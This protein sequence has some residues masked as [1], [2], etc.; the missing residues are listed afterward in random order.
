MPPHGLIPAGLFTARFQGADA[1]A[2]GCDLTELFYGSENAVLGPDAL[3]PHSTHRLLSWEVMCSIE[4]MDHFSVSVAN[5]DLTLLDHPALQPN[6]RW[7]VRFGLENELCD[8]FDC[9]LTRR[10]GWS[11]LTL[12]GEMEAERKL[13]LTQKQQKWTRKR[14]SDVAQDVFRQAGL[15]PVVDRT[16]H[17]LPVIVRGDETAWQFL[18]RKA[19]ETGLSYVVYAQGNKGYF[20]KQGTHKAP[21]YAVYTASGNVMD[22]TSESSSIACISFG[23]GSSFPQEALHVLEEPQLSDE[24]TNA[25][26]QETLKGFDPLAKKSFCVHANS[27]T[28]QQT[29][30]ASQPTLANRL[31]QGGE[32]LTNPIKT[33]LGGFGA[34]TMT[35]RA[36]PTSFTNK[37]RAQECAN[38][39]FATKQLHSTQLTCTVLGSPFLMP[40]EV[41]MWHCPAKSV[42]GR[43]LV[44]HV[45]HSCQSGGYTCE[46]QLQRNACESTQVTTLQA[47]T[48]GS[49][50]APINR[51]HLQTK[52]NERL[53]RFGGKEG[54]L[55][56]ESQAQA[57]VRTHK[58]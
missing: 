46:L 37:A 2:Q 22:L 13:T 20:V 18:Q 15:I 34:S 10:Q 9:V 57:D 33:L 12:E 58:G 30:L 35:G 55:Y 6:A 1:T 19:K 25:A 28:S 38:S 26:T 8:P 5:P 24:Q 51:K 53:Y 31:G 45:R 4:Q 54:K 36:R 47:R 14:L 7:R 52:P 32:A 21:R 39:C 49:T 56:R 48:A 50:R 11:Q 16:K 29:L 41:L 17:V 43:W 42:A 40:G 27:Q 3:K 44:Q 23:K